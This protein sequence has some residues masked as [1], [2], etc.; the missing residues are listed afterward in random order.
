MF[1]EKTAVE[2]QPEKINRGSVVPC[3]GPKAKPVTNHLPRPRVF[4]P[5][6][7]QPEK[8]PTFRDCC[9]PRLPLQAGGNSI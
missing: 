1:F 3:G 7:T 2:K 5:R 4:R 9:A 8:Q 6:W